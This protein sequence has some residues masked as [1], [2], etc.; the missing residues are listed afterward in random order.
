MR[1][2]FKKTDSSLNILVS[3]VTKFRSV[4]LKVVKKTLSSPKVGK[5]GEYRTL[6]VLLCNDDECRIRMI[7]FSPAAEKLYERIEEN[8]VSAICRLHFL[9]CVCD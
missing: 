7:A 8:A 1:K 2:Y 3:D 6:F 4:V 5:R 9:M